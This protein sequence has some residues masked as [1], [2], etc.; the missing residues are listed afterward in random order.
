M[1]RKQG[2]QIGRVRKGGFE[3]HAQHMRGIGAAGAVPRVGQQQP[4]LRVGVA[5]GQAMPPCGFVE[6]Q[7]AEVDR[8]RIQGGHVEGRLMAVRGQQMQRGV[9]VEAELFL[10][11]QHDG[12]A[13]GVRLLAQTGQRGRG[14]GGL[15]RVHWID[16]ASSKIG[17]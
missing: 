11:L 13:G 10:H 14:E 1:A 2:G 3:R 4:Q 12:L 7:L 15:R 16:P 6:I 9:G 5:R 8:Q 17:M